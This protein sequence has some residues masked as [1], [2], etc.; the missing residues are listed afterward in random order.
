[1]MP[2]AP[3]CLAYSLKSAPAIPLGPTTLPRADFHQEVGGQRVGG[4]RSDLLP[5][6]FVV[7]QEEEFVANDSPTEGAAEAILQS[8]GN[9]V[10]RLAER[11]T[12]EVG[13]ARPEIVC[14]AVEV[15]GTRTWSAP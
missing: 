6:S 13:V 3:S 11:V 1:M 15:V 7:T 10:R 12:R 14:G 8:A 4:R 9:A 5:L 2:A